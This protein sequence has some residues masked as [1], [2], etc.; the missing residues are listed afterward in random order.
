MS[1]RWKDFGDSM[2]PP[3]E[4]TRTLDSTHWRGRFAYGL[5]KKWLRTIHGKPGP[6]PIL[7][8]DHVSSLL[9]IQ[10]ERLGDLILAE[11]ALSALRRQFPQAKRTLVAPPF[12][13]DLFAGAGW[14][15][16]APPEAL[17]GLQQKYGGFDLV[18][19]LTG[20]VELKIAR[21]LKKSRIPNRVGMDRGG[22]GVYYTHAVAP[23]PIT[24]PT[25]E[26]YLKLTAS[27]G[28]MSEDAIPRLPSGEDRLARGH[29][30]WSELHLQDPV[31]IMPGAHFP[32]QRWALQSFAM[33][34]RVLQRK[35]VDVAVIVGPGERDMGERLIELEA[36]PL[37][38][39]PPMTTFMDMLAA[40]SVV[41]CN[42]TGP[43]HLAAALGVPT[44]STMGPTVPWRWWPVSDEPAIVFRGGSQSAIG[45]LNAID[46]MEVATA[47][48]H[49]YDEQMK[50]PR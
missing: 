32:S 9:V 47:A 46:P 25:R 1:D 27:I 2:P 42:N 50:Q 21:M 3:P 44:V 35:G 12:A 24:L 39:A 23:P 34:M 18:V 45:D 5:R 38:I 19:D 4:D 49:L 48:L 13:K 8:R 16:V 41:V 14:G 6:G 26:V 28:A 37:V 15:D 31:V 40:S 10:L 33:V 22:R 30:K 29:E 7:S 20:R 11:P 17:V 36:A 43:L